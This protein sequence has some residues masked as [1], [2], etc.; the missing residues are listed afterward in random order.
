MLS[1]EPPKVSHA[2]VQNLHLAA[3]TTALIISGSGC[4]PVIWLL[5]NGAMIDL[6]VDMAQI[7]AVA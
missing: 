2:S 1:G 7:H 6:A 5:N 3:W 4:K